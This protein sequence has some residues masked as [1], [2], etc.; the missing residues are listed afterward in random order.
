MLADCAGQPVLKKLLE[1]K[2]G[3]ITDIPL[4]YLDLGDPVTTTKYLAPYV[5]TGAGRHQQSCAAERVAELG[6]PEGVDLLCAG[7]NAFDNYTRCTQ[8]YSL[9]FNQNAR[10]RRRLVELLRN[11]RRRGVR[12]NA[13]LALTG[14]GD[15]RAIDALIAALRDTSAE[16]RMA[17]ANS[18]GNCGAP[19]A[20]GALVRVMLEDENTRVVH[21]A[22]RA[23][24]MRGYAELKQVRE[25]ME[26][27]RGTDRDGGVPGGP[28]VWEQADNSWVLRKYYRTYDDMTLCNLT[29]ESTACYDGATGRIVQWGSHGR[30]ADSPQTGLTWV[31]DT[32]TG[33][34]S[35]PAC[36]EQP[37][38]SCC[39]RDM[40]ADPKRG[41]MVV[42]KSGGV[43]GHGWLGRLR[44]LTSRSI[45]WVYDVKRGQWHPMRPV[46]DPGSHGMVATGYDRRSDAI[47]VHGGRERIYD[48]HENTWTT[49]R[50]PEPRPREKGQQPGAYDP[51]TGRFIMVADPDPRGRARTWAYDLA[52]NRWTDLKPKNPPPAMREPMV[53]DSANDVMLA[54]RPGGGR[55]TAYAYHL[56]ENRWEEVPASY[57]SPSYTQSDAIYDPVHNVTWL[58]GGWEWGS[59]GAVTTRETWTYRY[60]KPGKQRRSTEPRGLRLEIRDVDGKPAPSLSW[61]APS[62][63]APGGYNVYRGES[64]KPWGAAWKKLNGAPVKATGLSDATQL[65]TGKRYYYRVTALDAEGKEGLPSLL[66]HV[67]PAPVRRTVAARAADGSVSLSWDPSAGPG[68]VAY[69]VYRAEG[70]SADLWARPFVYRDLEGKFVK[71]NRKPVT[72]TSFTDRPQ[73]KA[74]KAPKAATSESTWAPF[75]VYIVRAVNSLGFE[76]GPGPATLSMPAA[77]GPVVVFRTGDG[78][79]LVI[80][81]EG[82]SQV[83]GHHLLRLDVYKGDLTFRS[84]GAPQPGTVFVDEEAWPVGHR[85]QYFVVG[86]DGAGQLGVPSSAGW[87]ELP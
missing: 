24:R 28:S 47:I 55:Y 77:P 87:Q 82:G 54:F 34:W 74:P 10:V 52:A 64:P 14:T 13:A 53:Y 80:S 50:P 73:D 11:S 58:I 9:Q 62:T 17:A 37:P 56:R 57:P 68:G 35:R 29:Y 2:S 46:R 41:L 4:R 61:R 67:R 59:S 45:P 78:R 79:R 26:R 12:M 23:L 27:I 85:R 25:A 60:R 81:G 38:G 66:A 22:L 20:A 48:L 21:Q 36:R 8:V 42:T 19:A 63:G 32:R 75:H 72:G 83:R 40:A 69:N 76:S 18:L 70:G 31:L 15:P 44:G 65:D 16:V 30:R 3:G 5:T 43:G 84:R 7:F 51:V 49:L 1:M 6:V 33:N 71:V 39:N 86:V